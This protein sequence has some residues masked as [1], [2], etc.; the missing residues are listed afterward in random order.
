MRRYGR[1]A[2]AKRKKERGAARMSYNRRGEA[3]RVAT[4]HNNRSAR[5][6]PLFAQAGIL[7]QVAPTI[8]LEQVE[9]KREAA[10]AAYVESKCNRIHA[11]LTAA[12]RRFR[13][14]QAR[15]VDVDAAWQRYGMRPYDASYIADFWYHAK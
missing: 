15:G 9:A 7:E 3:A 11:M 12:H 14:A 6:L 10:R 13:E 8:T 2:F 1:G 5:E 4:R